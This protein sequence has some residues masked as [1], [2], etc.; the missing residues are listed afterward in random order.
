[1]YATIRRY[2]AFTDRTE[3]LAK[4]MREAASALSST[5]GFVSFVMIEAETGVLATF[6]IF[7]DQDSL[8]EAEHVIS[9]SLSHHLS[10]L[11]AGPAQVTTGEIIFQRG[12]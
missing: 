8:H 2:E 1:M 10:E 6:G 5:P 7:E 3:E 9:A 4:A 12:L 11:L